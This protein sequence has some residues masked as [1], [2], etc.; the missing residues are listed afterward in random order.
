M[1]F[2]LYGIF[3]GIESGRQTPAAPADCIDLSESGE[4]FHPRTKWDKAA[5]GNDSQV[6][7]AYKVRECCG[8]IG[9]NADPKQC[10]GVCHTT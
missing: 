7:G 10:A 1:L 8:I 5:A 9:H 3:R 6:T 4:W 2:V